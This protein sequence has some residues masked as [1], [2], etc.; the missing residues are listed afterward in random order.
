VSSITVSRSSSARGY[1]GCLPSAT[2]AQ[3]FNRY[4]SERYADACRD[5][6]VVLVVVRGGDLEACTGDEGDAMANG[7]AAKDEAG[8]DE[9][10]LFAVVWPALPEGRVDFG[11]RP[12]EALGVVLEGGVGEDGASEKAEAVDGERACERRLN[13]EFAQPLPAASVGVT[14]ALAAPFL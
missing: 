6:V 5:G 14:M 4:P 7:E 3:P 13:V 1:Q 10:L 9:G 11:L 12:E 2:D 8:G